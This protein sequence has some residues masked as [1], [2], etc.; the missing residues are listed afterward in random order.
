MCRGGRWS[1]SETMSKLIC[2]FSWKTSADGS[3][4]RGGGNTIM[5]YDVQC[6][7]KATRNVHARLGATC[8][9]GDVQ[10]A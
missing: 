2:A 8:M 7:C 9:Q 4:A 10:R 3:E 1:L 5:I 6:A